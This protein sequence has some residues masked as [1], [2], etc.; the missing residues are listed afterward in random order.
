MILEPSQDALDYVIDTQPTY[1][2]EPIVIRDI[3][4]NRDYKVP[5]NWDRDIAEAMV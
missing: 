1:W 2:G 3:E 4:V 5:F